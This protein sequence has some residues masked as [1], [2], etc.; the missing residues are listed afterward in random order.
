MEREGEGRKG[1]IGKQSE[2]RQRWL[3]NR[4]HER[5]C[6]VQREAE[7]RSQREGKVSPCSNEG[8]TEHEPG[9]GESRS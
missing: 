6:E 2:E 1:G 3:E 8:L 5:V 7:L 4:L 9:R